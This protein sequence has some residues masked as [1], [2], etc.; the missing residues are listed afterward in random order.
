MSVDP[1][2]RIRPAAGADVASVLP[3]VAK[4]CELHRRWDASKYGFVDD[5]VARYERWLPER[6]A[7]PRSV[8]LVADAGTAIVGFI[9]GTVE[10]E[11]P[12]YVV[13]E[14]GFVHDTWVEP[15]WRGRGAGKQLAIEAL[16]KFSG[17]GLSQVRLDTAMANDAARALFTSV[18]FRSSVVEM[19]HE[20][21]VA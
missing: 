14:F 2:M 20:G 12:I 9:V 4:L 11:I 19:L 3:M 15:A 7:D 10:R 8:F 6:A 1:S 16:R 13:K 17:M 5:I 21:P 18:G